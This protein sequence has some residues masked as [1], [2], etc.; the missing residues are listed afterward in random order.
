MVGF[1]GTPTKRI[2]KETDAEYF[3]AIDLGD[4]HKDG[5]TMLTKQIP[6]TLELC[7]SESRA[8]C[9]KCKENGSC[10]LYSARLRV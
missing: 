7:D 3:N 5:G 2:V 1:N 8:N 4:E 9:L 10:P 6:S